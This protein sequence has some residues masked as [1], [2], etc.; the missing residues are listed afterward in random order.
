M[1]SRF[2]DLPCL[3]ESLRVG[4]ADLAGSCS[5]SDTLAV[6]DAVACRHH[7]LRLQSSC[8]HLLYLLDLR[9]HWLRLQFSFVHLL[10]L[11]G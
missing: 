11:P 6:V 2:L 4:E 3:L 9:H 10:Y 7:W 8:V 1:Q 5:G